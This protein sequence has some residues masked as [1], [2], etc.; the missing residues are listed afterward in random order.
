MNQNW[1]TFILIYCNVYVCMNSCIH[2]RFQ[3]VCIHACF[4]ICH[5]YAPL[6]TCMSTFRHMYVCAI[7]NIWSI[8][9]KCK[10]WW[11][12]WFA[13]IKKYCLQ[14]VYT[15]DIQTNLYVPM[16]HPTGK[17]IWFIVWFNW[18]ISYYLSNSILA[19]YPVS[20]VTCK[21]DFLTRLTCL[22]SIG[23]IF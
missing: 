15:L 13:F 8:T 16:I 1:L 5:M 9:S 23:C 7:F 2:A 20:S 6:Y 21:Y 19:C 18:T 17:W 10:I 3:H 11:E 14:H 12:Q 4:Y 22:H